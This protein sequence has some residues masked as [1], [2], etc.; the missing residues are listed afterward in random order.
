[1]A[2]S[3]DDKNPYAPPGNSRSGA[4]GDEG[5]S[6]PQYGR[7]SENWSPGGAQP[8]PTQERPWPVYGQSGTQ[9]GPYQGPTSPSPNFQSGQIPPG[10]YPPGSNQGGPYQQGAGNMGQPGYGQPEYGQP[11]FGQPGYGQ[12]G[13]GQPDMNPQGAGQPSP[14]GQPLPSRAG[15]IWTI[16]LGAVMMLI[17]APVVMLIVLFNGIGLDRFSDG[18]LQTTNGGTVVVDDTGVIGVSP[19]TSVT[20]SCTLISES[21][22]EILMSE[23]LDGTSVVVA[24]DVAPGTYTVQCADLPQGEMMIVFD[25]TILGSLVTT[26]V[27]SFAWASAIGVGGLVVLILGV[28][29]LVRRNKAVNTIRRGY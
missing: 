26:T 14:W 27:S 21:G 25:G 6:A 7:R 24:R 15:A 1:M 11:G 18:S 2:N 16:V 3:P 22:N 9:A 12:P 23:A 19:V 28:V 8:E 4:Q 29:W 17:I 13:H 5:S 20:A 10:P